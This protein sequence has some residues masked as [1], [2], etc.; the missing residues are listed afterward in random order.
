MHDPDHLPDPFKNDDYTY[1]SGQLVFESGVRYTLD[2]ALH[3]AKVANDH[4]CR[5][6]H[7]VKFLFTAYLPFSEEPLDEIEHIQLDSLCRKFLKTNPDR[8][9]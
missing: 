1:S 5:V 7:L 4:D 3:M 2:E 6:V 8:R 9:D